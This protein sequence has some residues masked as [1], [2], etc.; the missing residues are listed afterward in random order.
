MAF[1]WGKIAAVGVGRSCNAEEGG[2]AA[3][4]EDSREGS[5]RGR[6]VYCGP[7]VFSCAKTI[8]ARFGSWVFSLL[9]SR[10]P[11]HMLPPFL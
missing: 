3:G 11:D 4:I 1:I 9:C 6:E 10:A 5:A 7:S 8:T 2:M